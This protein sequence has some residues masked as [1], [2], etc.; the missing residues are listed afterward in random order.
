MGQCLGA[1]GLCHGGVQRRVCG[2][3]PGSLGLAHQQ[4]GSLSAGGQASQKVVLDTAIDHRQGNAVV[5]SQHA[6]R[7]ATG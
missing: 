1:L 4:A 6:D 5:A 2:P 3:L 7:S